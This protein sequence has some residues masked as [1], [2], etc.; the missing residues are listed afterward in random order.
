[1]LQSLARLHNPSEAISNKEV[2]NLCFTR[3]HVATTKRPCFFFLHGF[4]LER[5]QNCT[6]TLW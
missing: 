2:G 4:V 1:M 6:E 3:Q 5:L